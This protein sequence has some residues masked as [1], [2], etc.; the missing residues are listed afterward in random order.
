MFSDDD[1]PPINRSPSREPDREAPRGKSGGKGGKNREGG[2]KE[3]RSR[4]RTTGRELPPLHSIHKGTVVSVQSFGCFVR[5]GDG[6]KYKDGLLHISRLSQGRVEKVEE[7][8]AT[9]DIVWVKVVE[10]REE[11]GK[12]SVDMRYVGQKDGE[13]KDPNNT[14]IDAG[15]K[16]KGKPPPIR[17][18]AVQATTC[19]RCGAR[20]HSARECWA[21]GGTHYELL[22]E[23]RGGEGDN[24][25]GPQGSEQSLA[26]HDAKVARRALKAYIHGK[27]VGAESSD[28]ADKKKL[29]KMKKKEKKLKKKEKKAKK[30]EKKKEK[31]LKELDKKGKK[32]R[33]KEVLARQAMKSK[34]GAEKEEPPAKKSKAA[35]AAPSKDAGKSSGSSSSSSSS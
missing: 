13:D 21:A 23:P 32:D 9:E 24:A 29:K 10:V 3:G 8:V 4:V 30:K 19:S 28:E 22:E 33:L 25:A 26:G 6:S 12:F 34:E 20:G 5:L 18:G 17:I 31:E 16:G 27:D 1:L 2:G 7:V 11:E 15:G 35:A 14:Q